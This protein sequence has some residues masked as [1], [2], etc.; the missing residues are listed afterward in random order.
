[1]WHTRV[2]KI[3][4]RGDVPLCSYWEISPEMASSASTQCVGFDT[5]SRYILQVLCSSARECV[6][7]SCDVL[8]C[9]IFAISLLSVLHVSCSCTALRECLPSSVARMPGASVPWSPRRMSML[10]PKRLR[11]LFPP[12]SNFPHTPLQ[13]RTPVLLPST[14]PSYPTTPPQL[15]WMPPLLKWAVVR[16]TLL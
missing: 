9:I 16:T 5:C 3:L 14:Y 15:P 11:P 8:S 1:M 4:S 6:I 7:E 2:P 10:L 12:L 13:G